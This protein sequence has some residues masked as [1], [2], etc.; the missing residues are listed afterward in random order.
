MSSVKPWDWKQAGHFE[1]HGETGPTRAPLEKASL[2]LSTGQPTED[3]FICSPACSDRL[4]WGGLPGYQAPLAKYA[5]TSKP[6]ASRFVLC[7]QDRLLPHALLRSP[8]GIWVVAH[9]ELTGGPPLLSH[10]DPQ[11]LPTSSQAVHCLPCFPFRDQ[12]GSC[13][14]SGSTRYL[15]RE[16]LL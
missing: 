16:N 5:W 13:E 9:P 15:N 12:L 3:S 14:E 4:W 10:P 7:F 11:P 1:G 6:E 8:E 2:P